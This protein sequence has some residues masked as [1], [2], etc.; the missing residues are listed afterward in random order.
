MLALCLAAKPEAAEPIIARLTPEHFTSPILAEVCERLRDH[1]T[2]PLEGLGD[3][4][5][6][7]I[8]AITRLQAVEQEEPDK[9]NLSFRWML[10]ERD[11][12][13]RK[14]RRSEE[15]DQQ[16]LVALQK[17]RA[18]LVDEISSLQRGAVSD[19]LPGSSAR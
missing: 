13:D 5:S 1:L 2:A 12:L 11:R 14:L 3:S 9:A 8:N 4:D 6:R 15:L 19:P 16:E 17:Q 10:L 18:E 7:L